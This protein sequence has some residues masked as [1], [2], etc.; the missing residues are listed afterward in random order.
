MRIKYLIIGFLL[1]MFS[2]KTYANINSTDTGFVLQAILD[3][4]HA[5]MLD[6]FNLTKDLSEDGGIQK[7][8]KTFIRDTLTDPDKVIKFLENPENG[9]SKR[10]LIVYIELYKGYQNWKNDRNANSFES[11]FINAKDSTNIK[12]DKSLINWLNKKNEYLILYNNKPIETVSQPLVSEMP[13]EKNVKVEPKQSEN[14]TIKESPEKNSNNAFA[15]K[16]GY[17]WL[18]IFSIFLM[19]FVFIVFRLKKA[20]I[21]EIR[22]EEKNKVLMNDKGKLER[23][24][25]E[26]NNKFKEQELGNSRNNKSGVDENLDIK[27]QSNIGESKSGNENV[28]KIERS[29]EPP[30]KDYKELFFSIASKE[31]E[32]VSNDGSY[33]YDLKKWFKIIQE[34]GKSVGVFSYIS[35]ADHKRAI[36]RYESYILP[37]CN[38]EGKIDNATII[39]PIKDG[40]VELKGDKWALV[41]KAVVKFE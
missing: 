34:E 12:D 13:K 20:M 37:V 1:F 33:S 9:W 31:G 30:K 24:L 27:F 22:V 15:F 6:N 4:Q 3:M 38:I 5:Y 2:G 25:H 16:L 26:I 18:I 23:K 7:F 28:K 14:I 29:I 10:G 32:F 41:D 11:I 8:E 39:K 19:F 21:N 17:F 40:K 35:N 36:S